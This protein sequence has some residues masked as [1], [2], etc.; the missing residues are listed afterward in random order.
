MHSARGFGPVVGEIDDL[1]S[2]RAFDCGVRFVDETLQPLG[3]PVIAAGLSELAVHSLLYNDPM[4]VVGHNEPM[5]VKLETV[6][7][8]GT[9]DLRYKRLAV[10][11]AA[12][13]QHLS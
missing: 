7:H 9:V 11:S 4:A 12:P 6:L 8:S 13:S 3:K 10:A 2:T 5:Q 1:G